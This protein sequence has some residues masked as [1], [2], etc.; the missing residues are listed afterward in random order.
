MQTDV[1]DINS[2]IIDYV[3]MKIIGSGKVV[4]NENK[5]ILALYLVNLIAK[6]SSKF[7]EYF[8]ATGDTNMLHELLTDNDL[9][10]SVYTSFISKD[11]EKIGRILS[12]FLL[13]TSEKYKIISNFSKNTQTIVAKLS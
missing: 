8:I 2:T 12:V 7:D 10:E 5:A 1:A 4:S 6:S 3:G 13:I 11:Y 9:L